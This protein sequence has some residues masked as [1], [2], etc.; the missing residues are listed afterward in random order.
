MSEPCPRCYGRHWVHIPAMDDP[1]YEHPCH[2]CNPS[3]DR[4]P[5]DDYDDALSTVAMPGEPK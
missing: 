4:P 1:Y 5:P 3:G 2:L